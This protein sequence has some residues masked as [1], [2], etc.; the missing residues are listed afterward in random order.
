MSTAVSAAYAFAAA[1]AIDASAA[2][3][4]V[5]RAVAVSTAR[6]AASRR[7]RAALTRSSSAP[8]RW[9]SSGSSA[10]VSESLSNQG[11]LLVRTNLAASASAARAMPLSMAACSNWAKAPCSCGPSKVRWCGTT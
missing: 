5:R 3:S 2:V 10:A 7:A 9:T 1:T 4:S 11:R 8:K 6:A